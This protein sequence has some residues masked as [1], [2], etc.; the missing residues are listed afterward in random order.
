VIFNHRISRRISEKVEDRA[1][2]YYHW[3]CGSFQTNRN[4][5]TENSKLQTRWRPY[6]QRCQCRKVLRVLEALCI[7]AIQRIGPQTVIVHA[8][9]AMFAWRRRV[10]K[11]S[12]T[13]LPWTCVYL[14]QNVTLHIAV[15]KGATRRTL[16]YKNIHRSTSSFVHNIV[17]FFINCHAQ[18]IQLLMDCLRWSCELDGVFSLFSSSR[19]FCHCIVFCPSLSVC[20]SVC[21]PC[22][23]WRFIYRIVDLT[24]KILNR[25]S[26]KS[27]KTCLEPLCFDS[28]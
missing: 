22:G 23:E 16:R 26:R 24:S 8:P 27:A 14:E 7:D 9:G 1:Q 18:L 25:F 4:L 13:V 15:R 10:H 19:V 2:G 5:L 11:G 28:W 6:E 17:V 20:L 12:K 3:Q 21:Y